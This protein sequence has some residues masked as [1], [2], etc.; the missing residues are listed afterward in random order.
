[1]K[2]TQRLQAIAFGRESPNLARLK[3]VYFS[4]PCSDPGDHLR[5]VVVNASTPESLLLSKD[6]G[7][8][9]FGR[10]ERITAVRS[11]A[12]FQSHFLPPVISCLNLPVNGGLTTDDRVGSPGRCRLGSSCCAIAS[13]VCGAAGCRLFAVAV[14]RREKRHQVCRSVD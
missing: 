5:D 9:F 6:R 8:I 3:S 12:S 1:M 11:V 2:A 13:L 10:N 7:I 14:S 4:R